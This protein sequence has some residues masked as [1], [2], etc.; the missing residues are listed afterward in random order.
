[1]VKLGRYLFVA[2]INLWF[3]FDDLC[4]DLV[5]LFICN[6]SW[7]T[8]YIFSLLLWNH[9]TNSLDSV[10]ARCSN[11]SFTCILAVCFHCVSGND[12]GSGFIL[13]DLFLRLFLTYFPSCNLLCRNFGLHYSFLNILVI[14]FRWGLAVWNCFS[15]CFNLCGINHVFRILLSLNFL[16]LGCLNLFRLYNFTCFSLCAFGFSSFL[17]NGGT[18]GTFNLFGILFHLLIWICWFN[19]LLNHLWLFFQLCLHSRHNVI[20]CLWDCLLS[21][22][23]SIH[24]ILCCLCGLWNYFFCWLPEILWY[25]NLLNLINIGSWY[26]LNRLF[27]NIWMF[28]SLDFCFQS[29]L[30]EKLLFSLHLLSLSLCQC[31]CSCFC[32]CFFLCFP[33]FCLLLFLFLFIILFMVMLGVMLRM[34]MLLNHWGMFKSNTDMLGVIFGVRFGFLFLIVFLQSCHKCICN[35]WLPNFLIKFHSKIICLDLIL[36]MFQQL[37]WWYKSDKNKSC[38]CYSSHYNNL[39]IIIILLMLVI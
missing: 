15:F 27:G 2:I 28:W 32:R 18:D 33:L 21:C 22:C 36:I 13:V 12:I 10:L 3:L 17:L 24:S 4:F 35:H 38:K 1:M 37:F 19:F 5:G 9:F 16:C 14:F 26:Y 34:M 7:S 39:F 29:L 31:F 23:I 25:N 6:L 8:H 20:S 11:V 30:N